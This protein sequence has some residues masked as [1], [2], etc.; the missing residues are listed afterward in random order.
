MV[1]PALLSLCFCVTL[2]AGCGPGVGDVSGTVEYNGKVV[3]YADVTFYGADGVPHAV[4]VDRDGKY[5]IKKVPAGKCKVTVSSTN[6]KELPAGVR[7]GKRYGPEEVD[8]KNWFPIPPK[9]EDKATSG[10]EFEVTG[11]DNNIPI[12]LK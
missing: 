3:K 11:G 10:L 2:L 7:D 9:Y 1:R 4:K 6:P 5:S 12:K 8:I